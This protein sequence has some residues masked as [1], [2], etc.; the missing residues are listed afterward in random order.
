VRFF[1]LSGILFVVVLFNWF[2]NRLLDVIPLPSQEPAYL[3]WVGLALLYVGFVAFFLWMFSR[4]NKEGWK[5]MS[6]MLGWKEEKEPIKVPKSKPK[7]PM[8]HRTEHTSRDRYVRFLERLDRM[9]ALTDLFGIGVGYFVGKGSVTPIVYSVYFL[10]PFF[11]G[12]I[13]FGIIV[14]I[15]RGTRTLLLMAGY[16][17]YVVAWLMGLL[18]IFFVGVGIDVLYLSQNLGGAVLFALLL[19]VYLYSAWLKYRL[20]GPLGLNSQPTTTT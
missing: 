19:F 1:E 17:F 6:R 18:A 13:V 8:E 11:L 3:E 7:G 4:A 10:V 2:F 9:F 14:G 5:T 12:V 15:F 20:R 16:T